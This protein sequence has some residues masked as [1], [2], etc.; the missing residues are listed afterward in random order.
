MKKSRLVEFSRIL[1]GFTEENLDQQNIDNIDPEWND[2]PKNIIEFIHRCFMLQIHTNLLS[3]T[4]DLN[5]WNDYLMESSKSDVTL[6]KNDSNDCIYKNTML[7]FVGV[8]GKKFNGKDTVSDYI[9]REYGFIK[10][11]YATPLKEACR[12]LFGFND[13]QL[14]GSQKEMMDTRWNIT[15]RMAF[16][17]IGTDLFRNKLN[18]L[19]PHIGDNFWI[20]CLEKLIKEHIYKNNNAKI[21]VSDIRFQNEIDSLKKPFATNPNYKILRVKRMCKNSVDTHDSEKFIDELK[22]IDYEIDNNSTLDQLY[23]KID[24]IFCL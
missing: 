9:C 17:Y 5:C 14:Y 2:S 23:Q 4:I 18:K 6:L 22:C 10:L 21:I 13:E 12:V 11:S 1:F 19:L 15:P 24:S 16:Q 8:T 3:D 20:K 7:Q